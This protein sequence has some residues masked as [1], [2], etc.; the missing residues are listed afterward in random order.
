MTEPD[1]RKTYFSGR[2]CRKYAGKTGFL[3]F[4]RDFI[5]SFDWIFAQ[6]CVLI[7]PKIWSSLIFEKHFFP[8]ENAGNRRFCRFSL[9]FFHIFRCFYT[10]TL[11]ITIPTIK[12]GSIVNKTDFWS[13][14]FLKIVGTAD[15]RRKN[16]ISWISRAVLYIYSW[17]F[18]H[19]C[20]MAMSKIWRRLIF[21]KHIFLAENAGNMPVFWHFFEI[22]SLVFTDSL[23]NNA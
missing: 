7:M 23:F 11:L 12:H 21:E 19:C 20:K 17:N 16:G 10:K 4:S 13:R 5:I 14:N 2:K 3:A 6:R 1:F 22:S 18:A 8:A 15:F 9:D